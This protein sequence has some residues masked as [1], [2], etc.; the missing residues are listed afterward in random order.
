MA[1]EKEKMEKKEQKEVK[2]EAKK[3]SKASE[4]LE[5]AE[6][7]EK[8]EKAEAEVEALNAKVKELEE[9][10]S[11]MKDEDLRYRADTENFKKRLRADK[12][13]AVKYANEALITDLL[14]PIDNFSRAIEAAKVNKDFDAMAKG[15]EMVEDQMLSILKT[16]WGLESIETKDKEFNPNEMEAYSA[17]EDE[18]LDKEMVIAEFAKGWRLHDKVIRSAKVMVGKPKSK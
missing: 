3:E 6:A 12:D 9:T 2:A 14:T 18:N 13:N 10:I 17:K 16:N 5:K 11:H 15:V 8:L 1:D 4:K 7:S